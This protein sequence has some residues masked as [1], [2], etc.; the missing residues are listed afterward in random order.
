MELIETEA[1]I[2][3]FEAFVHESTKPGNL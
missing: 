3:R 1:V 2:E